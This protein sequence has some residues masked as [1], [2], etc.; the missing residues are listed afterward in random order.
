M[1]GKEL[2]ST[3]FPVFTRL[4][5]CCVVCYYSCKACDTRPL[6]MRPSTRVPGKLPV[7]PLSILKRNHT[8][9]ICHLYWDGTWSVLPVLAKFSSAFN[10]SV[11]TANQKL[12]HNTLYSR[13]DEVLN[14]KK[15]TTINYE[16]VKSDDCRNKNIHNQKRLRRLVHSLQRGLCRERMG[17]S[18]H[19]HA[20]AC[21]RLA[22]RAR[23]HAHPHW[24][25]P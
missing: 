9:S 5:L 21:R 1:E 10:G 4:S 3:P 11:I 6:R 25:P 20:A 17:A 22:R 13:H 14:G 19:P 18:P 23:A 15:K 2:H 12:P 24:R 7:Q 16:L 8:V